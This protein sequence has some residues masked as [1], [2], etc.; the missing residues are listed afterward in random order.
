M[1]ATM[2]PIL[3]LDPENVRIWDY[4]NKRRSQ[5]LE[6]PEKTLSSCT[7]IHNQYLLFEEKDEEGNWPPVSRPQTTSYYNYSSSWNSNSGIGSSY[8]Y[9]NQGKKPTDPGLCGLTNLG[10]TCFMNSSLQCLSNSPILTHYCISNRYKQEINKDNVLGTGGKLV[11]EYA[12]LL[13]DMWSGEYQYI[14]PR[15]FKQKLQTFAPQFEGMQ[16]HDSQ[17]LLAYLLDGLHE[18]LNRVRVKPYIELKEADGRPD[19]IVAEEAWENHLARN[20]SVIVDWYHGQLKSKLTCP[21]CD[22]VSVTFDPCMYLS[23]PLPMEKNRNIKVTFVPKDPLALPVEYMLTVPKIGSIIDLKKSLS[24]LAGVPIENMV[25]AELWHHKMYKVYTDKNSVDSIQDNDV[26]RVYYVDS[27][28]VLVE[29][30]EEESEDENDGLRPSFRYYSKPHIQ[31]TNPDDII[32]VQVILQKK[33]Q[34]RSYYSSMP[35]FVA[36]GEPFVIAVRRGITYEDLHE[37]VASKIQRFVKDPSV[38]QL[39]ALPSVTT[40]VNT[41]EETDDMDTAMDCND[42]SSKD[43]EF[44]ESI[45]NQDSISNTDNQTVGEEDE[46]EDAED[47]E[48]DEE[49]DCSKEENFCFTLQIADSRGSKSIRNINRGSTIDFRQNEIIAVLFSP[50]LVEDYQVEEESKTEKHDTMLVDDEEEEGDGSI[51]ISECLNLYTSEEQLGPDD[52]WYCNKCKDHKQATKKFDLWKL[53]PLLVI[54]LK[55]FSYG[56]RY[57]REKLDTV[58]KF[59]L[60]GLDL[61]EHLLCKDMESEP[62]YDLV[63]V[64]VSINSKEIRRYHIFNYLY[65]ES[66][67]CIRWWSLYCIC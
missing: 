59:P 26:I 41:T 58:V 7:I 21:D 24:E 1:K 6:D 2:C 22:R 18:D 46:E 42:D 45:N 64:S 43:A 57:R 48:E 34:N 37:L 20:N 61:T 62:I 25:V 38:L 19:D 49:M 31:P 50:E 4:H 16:Q 36:F 32:H 10:N 8:S 65:L 23:L 39:P 66:F 17:E 33:D 3:E 30:E 47:E 29:K 55:R 67:W 27:P 5:I 15:T 14:A 40:T 56:N 54:H 44:T 28:Q 60:T 53:P 13:K 35:S 51:D 12:S 52:L 9:H 63:A 11:E